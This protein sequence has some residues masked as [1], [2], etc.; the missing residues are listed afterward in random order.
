MYWPLGASNLLYLTQLIVVIF[1]GPL[2]AMTTAQN[3]RASP[4]GFIRWTLTSL[5]LI[6]CC[7]PPPSILLHT[8]PLVFTE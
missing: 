3:R 2:G 6:Y 4:S 7:H 5:H 8:A 1:D